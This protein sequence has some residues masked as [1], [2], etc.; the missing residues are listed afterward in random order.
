MVVILN[1]GTLYLGDSY[2]LRIDSAILDTSKVISKNINKFDVSDRG[3]L[4]QNILSQLR[5][6]VEYVAEKVYAKGVDIDPNNYK[7]KEKALKFVKTQGKLRFLTKF[8]SLLQKSVSHYT[9]DEDGSERLMLKYYEYLLKIK[10]FLKNTYDLEVLE[11]ISSFPL[12][13]DSHLMEYYEKIVEKI[14]NKKLNPSR[15]MYNDRYYIQK[16]KPFFVNQDI[17]YEVTFTAAIDKVSKFDRV[18]AFTNLDIM[19]NYA[20][21]FSIHNDEISIMGKTMF[22]QIIDN[23]EVSIRPCELSNF[24]RIFGKRSNIDTGNVEYRELMQFLTETQINLADL[25][26]SSEAFYTWVR[27]KVTQ[28]ARAVYFFNILDKCRNIVRTDAPGINIIKYLLYKMNNKIEKLQYKNESCEKLSN[29]YLKYECIPFDQMPFNTSLKGH[30]PKIYD[31]LECI[32]TSGRDYEFFARIIKNNTEKKGMLFTPKSDIT[33]FDNM[34]ELIREYNSLVY[35]KHLGRH[36]KEYKNHLYIREYADDSAEIIKKIKKLSGKGVVG[37]SNFVKSWLQNTTYKIDCEEKVIALTHMFEN[38]RVAL[39][40]GSAGTGKSTLIDY[41]SN[42]FND[43]TKI[44]LANTNPA[45]DNLRRKVS[46]AKCEFKTIK[47]FLSQY[48]KST[49]A[50]LLIIDECSTVSNRDMCKIL[51]TANFKLLVL[52]GD[53]F[54]IESILFG[55]WFNIARSFIP[56]K[57]CTELA[58]TYRSTNEELLTVWD[59]VR[60]LD[61]AILEPMV[62]NNYS[63]ALDQTIFEHSDDDEI[64]LCLNYDGLYGINNINRFLQSSNYN[65]AVEWGINLYKVGDPIL[66]N[67][68]ERFAPLIYNNMKGKIVD[69]EKLDY[70][71]RFN[72]ELEIAINELDEEIYDFDFVGNSANG[73]TIISFWTNKYKSTDEDDDSMDTIIPFQV[74]YAVSIHK[75]QGLEYRSVKVVITNEVE[76]LITHNIFYTAITR[77]KEKLKIYWTPETENKILNSFEI[78]NNH[79]DAALLSSL[80]KL[81]S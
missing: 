11:N 76:D 39:I 64:I 71:I 35:Y 69:I 44:F 74:A 15:S 67:E 57:L 4:S 1:M 41:I 34:D 31:L 8:H 46:A 2:M 32:D 48:N 53:V 47:K 22:I 77:A 26:E 25:V 9:I 50:D 6:F 43:K 42:L 49:D 65:L 14:N 51:N 23:W 72:I 58:K 5:N 36:I 62:K 37:Y 78:K 54:Q 79:K 3:L 63:V 24:I 19:D 45:V 12:N 52:V 28:E 73:N 80:Y 75:A 40:Y 27:N 29:L 55:N 60:K 38:S 66:F 61:D 16:I 20:V 10:V 56:E 17:Y 59:R 13:L 33:G 81:D 21:K 70:K 30:N 18:I 68:S 7:Q